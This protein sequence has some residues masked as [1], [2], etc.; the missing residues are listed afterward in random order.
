MNSPKVA[1]AARS[2]GS[3]SLVSGR[4]V[5][6]R[7]V[8]ASRVAQAR[9]FSSVDTSR[10]MV[11]AVASIDNRMLT[12]PVTAL[13]SMIAEEVSELPMVVLDADV[14]AQPMRGPLGAWAAGD[15]LGLAATEPL[16]LTR[17]KMENFADSS[18]AVPLLTA[19]Q[20]TQGQ[21]TADVLD[22]VV[23]RAQH[24]WPIVVVNLPYTCA[25]ETI[26]AGT[27]MADHVLLVADRHHEQHGWLYQPGHHLTELAQ[28]K[29]VTVVKVG[30][31]AV[32]L[33]Q[34]TVVLPSV[35]AHSTSRSRIVPSTNPEDVSMYHR[36]LSRVF[37]S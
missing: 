11:I 2:G 27:A 9:R 8:W 6:G 36:L 1:N 3:G 22:T 23:S 13:V 16:D 21:M 4:S 31:A 28:S 20:G 37:G 14:Q 24:K 17:K 35:D 26:A 33:P 18:G 32:D 5:F 10:P 7:A 30:A 15:V 29:K 19:S 25:G 12:S 34:D